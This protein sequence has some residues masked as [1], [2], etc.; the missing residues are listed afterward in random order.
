MGELR[1]DLPRG[2]TKRQVAKW[3]KQGWSIATIAE[4]KKCR[5]SVI[6]KAIRDVMNR[7]YR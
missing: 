1:W 4:W 3:F 2:T 6:E 7:K 5:V